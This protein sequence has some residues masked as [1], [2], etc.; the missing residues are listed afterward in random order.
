[1]RFIL[2]LTLLFSCL[3]LPAQEAF[4]KNRWSGDAIIGIK[5]FKFSDEP[6]KI[7]LDTL[8]RNFPYGYITE[9]LPDSTFLSYNVGWCGNE[10]RILCKGTYN[11]TEHTVQLFVISVSH[12]K[13]FRDKPTEEVRRSIALYR[14][15]QKDTRLILTPLIPD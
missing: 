13:D 9:F 2:I 1:M 10:S 15:E 7:T 14:W 6:V 11:V 8:N 12:A 4:T 5:N 3:Y